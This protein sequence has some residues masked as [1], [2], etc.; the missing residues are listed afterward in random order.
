MAVADEATG[1]RIAFIVREMPVGGLERVVIGLANALAGSGAQVK[2]LVMEDGDNNL[3]GELDSAVRIVVMA[4]S[5]WLRARTLYREAKGC[6][7]HVHFS[8]GRVRPIF[9]LFLPGPTVVTY[10]NRYFRPKAFDWADVF[11]SRAVDVLVAVSDEVRRA[12]LHV[13]LPE[14]KLLVIRN[15]VVPPQHFDGVSPAPGHCVAVARAVPQKDYR[16]LLTGFARACTLG[17]ELQLTVI[18]SGPDEAELQRL[19]VALGIGP[20][21]SWL[22][23]VTSAE[24]IHA[25]RRRAPIFLT[26]SRWEG[27]SLSVLEAM[28][29][30]QAV[31]ASDISPHREAL[32][33]NG[34][35]FAPGDALGMGEALAKLAADQD[36][37][38]ELGRR[39]VTRAASFSLEN[40]VAEHVHLYLTLSERQSERR[41]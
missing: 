15:G 37:Q 1:L 7:A 3:L 19:A 39:G 28:A 2:V 23:E 26:A 5:F 22:G 38:A 25:T 18:G 29:A 31:V 6:V 21:V 20:R 10:H 40:C 34:V 27:F 9:R 13:G 24:T 12:C 11:C 4:G 41:R 8:E 16:T 30:G 32:G 33:E 36:R 14:G 17:A 35:Y